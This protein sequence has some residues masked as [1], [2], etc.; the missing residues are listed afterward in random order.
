MT[1]PQ[2]PRMPTREVAGAGLMGGF[3][4]EAAP[5]GKKDRPDRPHCRS[6]PWPARRGELGARAHPAASIVE[7][8]EVELA[9][10]A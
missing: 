8:A 5:I 9:A 3:F 4:R 10:L 6:A 7:R 1:T 2:R